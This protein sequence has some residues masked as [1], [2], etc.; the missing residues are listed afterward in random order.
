M[1]SNTALL[2]ELGVREKEVAYYLKNFG[3][4]Q[5]SSGRP[6]AVIKVGGGVVEDQLDQL[7]RSLQYINKF[8]LQPVVVHGA[9]PQLNAA[10]AKDG[11]VSQYENGLR[12]TSPQIME[13][14]R[15]VMGNVNLLLSTALERAGVRARPIQQG[16][17]EASVL[18]SGS[19]GLVGDITRVRLEQVQSALSAG[20]VPV[21]TCLGAD[22]AGQALNINADMAA[23]EL[24]R[25]LRPLK[26]VYI[27]AK[28][29]LVDEHGAR[30]SSINIG[31]DYEHLMQQPWFKHG[32]RLKLRQIKQVLDALP[33]E[34]SVAV[35]S[36]KEL[37]A[38]LFSHAGRGTIIR[39]R[40][41]ILEVDSLDGIERDR[42]VAL[43]EASFGERLNPD[44]LTSIQDSIE[45]IY[46]SEQ[47]R[48][49]AIMT[50]LDDD[51][52]GHGQPGT[53]MLNKFAVQAQF[54]SEG[55]GRRLWERIRAKHSSVV[56]RARRDNPINDFYFH[57]ADGAVQSDDFALFWYGVDSLE[58]IDYYRKQLF[59]LPRAFTA[60]A[61]VDRSEQLRI[62]AK[63]REEEEKKLAEQS[64]KFRIGIIGARGYTGGEFM[65]LLDDHPYAQLAVASSRSVVGR[66]V[67]DV[68]PT[69]SSQLE[70]VDLSPADAASMASRGE[71]DLWVLAMPNDASKPFVEA[72]PHNAKI[73]DLSADHR[74]V[75][76]D[77]GWAYGLPERRGAR[78]LIRTSTRVA[79][80]GCYAT[81]AQLS[82]LPLLG[83]A[84]D[85][86]DSL[87][88]ED[89]EPV[90]F[91]ISGY[92]GAGT[93]P[94]PKNDTT[95][96][97]DNL[98]AYGLSGHIHEREISHKLGTKVAFHPH[99]A[100]WFRG[101]HQT[102]S[103]PLA[104]RIDRDALIDRYRQYY[105][106][107][108]LVVVTP[109]IPEV[110]DI[111]SANHVTIGGFALSAKQD[112]VIFT[113]TID[114]LRKG[115][116]SAAIQ[117]I[118]LLLGLPEYSGITLPWDPA[119]N[120]HE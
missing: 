69:C 17:F 68:V 65:E 102:I 20:C 87:L 34:S 15:E 115:A 86:S 88:D 28:G 80:P 99:V 27:S 53:V 92:S 56:W 89:S 108:P 33:L 2:E 82:L 66:L 32:D 24:S 60:H 98:L 76:V 36:P 13:K 35:V 61:H 26:V 72:L 29:S 109:D 90:I 70:F 10:L 51:A 5:R 39:N 46:V 8:G 47:Y 112:R 107:E 14:A 97:A 118:N 23:Q 106:H 104:D 58:H 120:S 79:N 52:D 18:D 110:R 101:I 40:E 117:N 95:R 105:E 45:A 48:G 38:E 6:F 100:S 119:T 71:V 116:A 75:D 67:S 62:E 31:D 44:F 21:L 63:Q 11:I 50:R 12:V 94:S 84:A 103:V 54:Q 83:N 91:G 114:N 93:T 4:R 81:C 25:A 22:R 78:H 1:L 96:L 42:L 85:Q 37:A 74:F 3:A 41:R 16:V 77:Q 9:G 49:A 64:N 19:L 7:V 43:L 113:S 111:A 30:I 59:A 73:V 57:N 55:L